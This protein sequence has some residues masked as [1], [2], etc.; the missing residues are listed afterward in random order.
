MDY[1]GKN[2]R[3]KVFRRMFGQPEQPEQPEKRQQY[4]ETEWWN[5]R[6]VK[7]LNLNEEEKP[8]DE[9]RFGP[10]D[11]IELPPAE[12]VP[13]GGGYSSVYTLQCIAT[14]DIKAGDYV[15]I[16]VGPNGKAYARPAAPYDYME[17]PMPQPKYVEDSQ[18]Y[19]RQLKY[20]I[21]FD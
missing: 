3:D 5:R 13:S 16:H 18:G 11:P 9:Y 6:N 10:I 20:D 19:S 14:E 7:E 21:K 8:F 1:E 4:P 12:A 15:E 17:V 2:A